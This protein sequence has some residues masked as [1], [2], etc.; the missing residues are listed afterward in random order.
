[1]QRRCTCTVTRM[2]VPTNANSTELARYREFG[3]DVEIVLL[4]DLGAARANSCGHDGSELYESPRLLKFLL[5][6]CFLPFKRGGQG[7]M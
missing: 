6:D 4:K 2:L 3:G 5:A 1:M 7:G